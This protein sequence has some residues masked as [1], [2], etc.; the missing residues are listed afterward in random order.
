MLENRSFFRVF[1]Y[2]DPNRDKYVMQ[3]YLLDDNWSL[4]SYVNY[5]HDNK[6]Y[7][8][9]PSDD[10][11]TPDP[12][13]EIEFVNI[14]VEGGKPDGYVRSYHAA[15]IFFIFFFLVDFNAFISYRVLWLD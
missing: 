6:A 14:S 13:H 1:G 8:A 9:S 7:Y 5:S 2:L 12:P 10:R 4:C 11:E 3:R 15:F